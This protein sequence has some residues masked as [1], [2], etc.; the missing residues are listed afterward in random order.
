M[1]NQLKVHVHGTDVPDPMETFEDLQN[2]YNIHP[3]II[4]NIQNVGFEKPT[5]IQVQA[6]PV[7]LQVCWVLNYLNFYIQTVFGF[8]PELGQYA[9]RVPCPHH[10]TLQVEISP[11][12]SRVD[13]K[14]TI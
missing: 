4:E 13:N 7:M 12:L 2:H 1:R 6:I 3:K 10:L 14:P 8:N 9:S 5:P 11:V